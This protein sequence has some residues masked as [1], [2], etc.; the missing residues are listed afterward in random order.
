MYKSVEAEDCN[1][2]LDRYKN[3][4]TKLYDILGFN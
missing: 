4:K 2:F 3:N 1:V